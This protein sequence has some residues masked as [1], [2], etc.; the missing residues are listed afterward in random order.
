MYRKKGAAQPIVHTNTASHNEFLNTTNNPV[1]NANA[2]ATSEI[3]VKPMAK[4]RV[5][6]KDSLS[7]REVDQNTM[8]AAVIDAVMEMVSLITNAWKAALVINSAVPSIGLSL[9]R[10]PGRVNAA[11]N[12]N[13]AINVAMTE[14]V[15]AISLLLES[16]FTSSLIPA[17]A[18][19]SARSIALLL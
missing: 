11:V 13:V 2:I 10:S 12:V 8:T 19:T 16:L 5:S 14:I 1:T 4:G 17:F 6:M 3:H 7:R 9:V 15:W 18:E